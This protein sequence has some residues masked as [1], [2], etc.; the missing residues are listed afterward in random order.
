MRSEVQHEG[1]AGPGS[2]L[3]GGDHVLVE[4]RALFGPAV[5]HIGRVGVNLSYCYSFLLRAFV[6]VP[7]SKNAENTSTTTRTPTLKMF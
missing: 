6:P 3:A 4:F 7:A 1:R 5:G 2:A